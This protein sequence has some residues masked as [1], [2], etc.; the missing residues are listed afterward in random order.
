MKD[1]QTLPTWGLA[2]MSWL[3][4]FYFLIA[5][6]LKCGFPP[7]LPV[8]ASEMTFL[9]SG[10]FFILLPFFNKIRIP[11]IIELERTVQETKKELKTF[12]EHTSNMLAVI[13]TSINTIN[14]SNTTNIILPPRQ[15]YVEAKRELDAAAS[16]PSR[17]S[18]QKIEEKLVFDDEDRII[19]LARL[20]M[21]LEVLLRELLINITPEDRRDARRVVLQ[22]LSLRRL[23]D[24]FQEHSTGYEHL[25]RSIQYV[26]QVCNAAIHGQFISPEKADEAL[27]MG[28]KILTF[29]PELKGE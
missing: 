23:F 16:S 2:A 19:A 7:D 14:N 26:S 6:H 8:S 12:Q 15:D 24:E 9:V 22:R 1:G 4:A 17:D 29:L 18:I 3:L 5:F 28:A 11:K 20:R 13:S 21:K 10:I 27:E 25:S